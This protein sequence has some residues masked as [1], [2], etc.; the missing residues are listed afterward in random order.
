ML[1]V[2]KLQR[3]VVCEYPKPIDFQTITKKQIFY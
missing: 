2:N 1:I 3:F